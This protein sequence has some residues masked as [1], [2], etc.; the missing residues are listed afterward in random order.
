MKG[1]ARRPRSCDDPE[2]CA[3]VLQ[4]NHYGVSAPACCAYFD[5]KGELEGIQLEPVLLPDALERLSRME[6]T[7][8]FEIGIAGLENPELFRGAGKGIEGLIDLV[9]EFES[10]NAYLTMTMGHN[11]G[12]LTKVL[13][14]AKRLLSI[15]ARSPSSVTKITVTGKG[16]DFGESEVLDLLEHRMVEVVNVELGV[17]RRL[18]RSARKAA[19][20]QAWSEQHNALRSMLRRE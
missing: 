2:C 18:S 3:L 20:H 16:A 14:Y 11:R 8:K 4:R 9:N 17:D 10:P 19:V 15:S 5:V 6:V 13:Q 12:K 1:S 7:R